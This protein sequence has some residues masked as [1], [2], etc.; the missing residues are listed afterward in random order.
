MWAGVF[1][2]SPQAGSG[3]L[4][5]GEARERAVP[6]GDLWHS[7]AARLESSS[8]HRA[9]IL[10]RC[11]AAGLYARQPWLVATV[12]APASIAVRSALRRMV[13]IFAC[14]VAPEVTVN[15]SLSAL[16][17]SRVASFVHARHAMSH[18]V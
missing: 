18:P 3:A 17:T 2:R 15:F 5:P 8:V 14:T 16:V 13:N 10:P 1:P 12:V 6:Q 7:D 4:A 9:V 11:A